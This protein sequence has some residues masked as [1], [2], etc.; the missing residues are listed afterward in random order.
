MNRAALLAA[1]K[2]AAPALGDDG[3]ALPA[4]AHFCF[5]DDSLLAYNDV[6]AVIVAYKTGL[7]L[8]LH[9]S[10]LLGVLGA[11]R[12]ED[13]EIKVKGST[14][15]LV[16]GGRVE[17]PV[18]DK[19][20]FVFT[21][22]EAEPILAAPLS[23]E[24][25]QA[26]EVCLISVA[27]DSMR[28]EY[29]GVTFRILK[30]GALL[31]STDNNTATRVELKAK[32]VGRKEAALVLPKVAADLVLKL[33]PKDGKPTITICEKI[34]IVQF[35][36]NPDVTL[37]TKLLGTP[38]MKLDEVFK[39]HAT[40][41]DG[42]PLPDGLSAEIEKA[43]VLTSRDSLKEVTL[44]AGKGELSITVSASLGKMR[45]TL[46]LEDK[47]IVGS[48]TVSPEYLKRILPFVSRFSINDERSLVLHDGAGG[49][50][51]HIVSAVPKAQVVEEATEAKK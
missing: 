45:T 51:S 23:E 6:V 4:L 31:F 40:E 13:V 1:L 16:G 26:I 7:T 42:C 24:I 37:V 29:N 11:A 36:G 32:I 2:T 5:E 19:A 17:L 50:L 39:L 43:I 10:T 35:G 12:A 49:V 21:L 9:G 3:S 38:S 14:A 15:T 34:A 46:P 47:K 25:R 28:P 22:P 18:I 44:F 41:G 48:V 27:E 30:T 20:D 8:G 33:F